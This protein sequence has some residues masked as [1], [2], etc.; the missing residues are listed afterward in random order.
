MLGKPFGGTFPDV[1]WIIWFQVE[2]FKEIAE[3]VSIYN[4]C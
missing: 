4:S 3:I 1:E 2:A